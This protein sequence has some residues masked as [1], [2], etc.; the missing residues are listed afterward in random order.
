[1][2]GAAIVK[3]SKWLRR[4]IAS[5]DFPVKEFFIVNNNGLGEIDAELDEIA[6]APHPFIRKIRVTHLPANLGVSG[7]WNL[8]IKCYMNCPYWIIT[9]DDVAFG[10][11]FLAEMYSQAT[12]DPSIGVIHGYHGDFNVGSWD[13]F[14][15]RDHVIAEYGLFDENLYPAYNEDA[16]Y[17]MR[18]LHRPVKRMLGIN[19][20]YY[21]G[22]GKKNEYYTHG[23][24][25]AKTDSVLRQKLDVVNAKNI[26]YLTQ[27]WGIG[28][29]HCS[30]TPHPFENAAKIPVS[31]TS[32]DLQFVRD[33][34][35]GF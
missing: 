8:M 5:V 12:N 24:Q 6:R 1:M 10:E 23:S 11:G 7:A 26:D 21:H 29:R 17:I 30:P 31:Y 18:I 4:L 13:L 35:L 20:E 14:L 19:K 34:H 9:N 27:K 25:T 3:N 22:D 15:I 33:K 16:D 32:Y 2:I 28:W